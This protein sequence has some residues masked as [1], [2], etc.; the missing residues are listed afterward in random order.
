MQVRV[1]EVLAAVSLTTDLASGLPFEKGLQTCAVAT[2]FGRSIGLT[3]PELDVVFHAALL[4]SIGCTSHSSENA[5]AFGDDLR[6]QRAL[7]EL[8]VGDPARFAEQMAR[9]G[10]W[11]GPA[12]QPVL[13]ERF[14][15][16][17]PTVGPQAV[18]ASCEVAHAL[19]PR[20]GL[21]DGVADAL[22]DVYERWDGLGNP[23]KVSGDGLSLA[24]RV[25]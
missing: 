10:D 8:D 18:R 23:G 9:F 21:P 22:D 4:R 5:D 6:F 7:K 16:I 24:M 1:V 12:Q 15:R 11:A 13:A 25:V 3:E 14:Q 2:S 20:L 17:A 19:A